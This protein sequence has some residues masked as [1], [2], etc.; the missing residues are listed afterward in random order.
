MLCERDEDQVNTVFTKHNGQ[1]I[2]VRFV[3]KDGFKAITEL[4]AQP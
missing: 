1:E 2:K 4:P 3:D